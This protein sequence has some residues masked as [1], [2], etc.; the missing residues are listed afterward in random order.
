[1]CACNCSMAYAVI[2]GSIGP[3]STKVPLFLSFQGKK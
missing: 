2:V 1:V 3:C